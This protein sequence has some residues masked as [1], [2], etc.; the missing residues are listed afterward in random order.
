MVAAILFLTPLGLLAC[1]AA[2]VPLLVALEVGRRQRRAAVILGLRPSPLRSSVARAAL[3]VAACLAFGLAA[4]QPVL[5]RTEVRRARTASEVVFVIDVSRS[6]RAAGG[7]TREVRLERARSIVSRLRPAVADVPAGISGLTDRV[8]PYLFPTLD[9]AAFQETL[10]KSVRSESPPP[11]QVATVATD[12][13]AL[14]ALARDGFFSG[15]AK[16][17]TCVLVTDGEARGADEGDDGDQPP[18]L[19]AAPSLGSTPGDAAAAE[20]EGPVGCRLLVI[21]V[22]DETERIY[23]PDGLIEAEYRPEANAAEVVDSLADSVGGRSLR[24]ADL[25]EA[26]VA[27]RANA[28]AGPTSELGVGT[29]ARPLAGLLAGL[30]LGLA[31][32]WTS[33]VARRDLLLALAR[34]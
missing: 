27:L 2:L 14:T 29:T 18:S 7:P 16:R 13:A 11:S 26:R 30:G 8:L 3:A 1:L 32:F 15:R 20:L 28:E 9:R 22:G 10:R 24:E 6:M 17:R 23:G 21:R 33:L 34:N 4:G 31:L 5:E 19:R 12:F 25:R